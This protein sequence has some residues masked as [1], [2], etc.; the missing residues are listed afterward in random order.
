MMTE[1]DYGAK[2]AAFP[3]CKNHHIVN[4]KVRNL[5]LALIFLCL[6]S[7]NILQTNINQ[8][9]AYIDE[10]AAL[11]VTGWGICSC[12]SRGASA[13]SSRLSKAFAVLTLTCA[14]GLLGNMA[15]RVQPNNT[16]I[17][18]DLF[19]CIKFFL[20]YWGCTQIIN[21]D[22][23]KQLVWVLQTLCRPIVVVLFISM[24]GNQ[25]FDFGMYESSRYGIKSFQFLYGHPSTFAA[26]VAGITGVLL[27]NCRKNQPFILM[28]VLVLCSTMR[29]K[30]IGYGLIILLII[31][32]FWNKRSI[33][34]GF[35]I[36]AVGAA[37]LVASDQIATYF[38]TDGTAR[39]SLLLSSFTVAK[40]F[41]P[42]GSGFGS[43]GSYVTLTNYVNLY[44][45]LGFNRVFGL[46]EGNPL[47]LADMFWPTVLA[48]FGLFGFLSF[49]FALY[50]LVQESF[51]RQKDFGGQIWATASI[52]IYL[53]I[54]STSETAFFS[55]GAVFLA[56]SMVAISS[57]K[58]EV[59]VNE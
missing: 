49:I 30:A 33:S 46:T 50:F 57:G 19:T 3:Q 27:V 26:I 25:I 32:F 7:E 20:A 9:F 45:T 43:Y 17:A 8:V 16:A 4:L 59:D 2:Y 12:M 53:L 55:S 21:R 28:S 13:A 34:F 44:D 14:I 31:Y 5:V 18:I 35:I 23:A 38:S 10:A 48:Q 11:F 36:A 41:F 39:S 56:L 58:L 22:D 42:L 47:Y 6:V 40:M 24:I 37:L 54:S 51:Y 1:V 29:F 15:N 52:W